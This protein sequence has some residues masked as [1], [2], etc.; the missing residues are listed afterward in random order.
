MARLPRETFALLLALLPATAC[1]V[2]LVVLR[3]VP[4]PSDLAGIGLVI[5]GVALHR[6]ARALEQESRGASTKRRCPL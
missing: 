1:L 3:Q 2:G 4:A 6:E 5:A